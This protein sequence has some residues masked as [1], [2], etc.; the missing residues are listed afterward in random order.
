MAVGRGAV[1]LVATDDD[2]LERLERY[3]VSPRR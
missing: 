1:Y 3:P 2:G